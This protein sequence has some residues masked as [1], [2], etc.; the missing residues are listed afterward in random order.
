MLLHKDAIWVVFLIVIVLYKNK[1]VA[2]D[3]KDMPSDYLWCLV[4]STAVLFIGGALYLEILSKTNPDTFLAVRTSGHLLASFVI[5]VFILHTKTL[6]LNSFLGVALVAI[7][8]PLIV[9]QE[10][11]VEPVKQNNS[12]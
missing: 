8:I 11:N 1:G 2:A 6:T 10:R 5:A 4:F 3:F 7:G 9:Y 12:K